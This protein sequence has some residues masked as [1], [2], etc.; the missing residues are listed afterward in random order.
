MLIYESH[1]VSL[2][3]AS[4][5][6]GSE[7]LIDLPNF[8]PSNGDDDG[9]KGDQNSSGRFNQSLFDARWQSVSQLS[10]ALALLMAGASEP[11]HW[12]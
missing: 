8:V 7:N 11:L 3:K 4:P 2:P 6:K 5:E 9:N 1:R 12:V 10:H